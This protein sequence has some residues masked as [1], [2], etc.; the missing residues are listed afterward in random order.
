[1]R[2][3]RPHDGALQPIKAGPSTCRGCRFARNRRTA[4]VRHRLFCL[5]LLRLLL[6]RCSWRRALGL[7]RE[8]L[9]ILSRE[10]RLSGYANGYQNRGYDGER[11]HFCP[12]RFCNP[13]LALQQVLLLLRPIKAKIPHW[14]IFDNTIPPLPCALRGRAYGFQR[15]AARFGAHHRPTSGFRVADD[16]C[17]WRRRFGAMGRS[18]P[19]RPG[20][21][22]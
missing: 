13:F 18:G 6:D 10:R 15:V 22:R 11:P 3:V 7:D 14:R 12:T 16:R 19:S 21:I 5:A 2:T 4:L 20:C 17:F 9:A 8:L 1:M